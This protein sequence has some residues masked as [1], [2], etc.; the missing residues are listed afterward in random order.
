MRG[1]VSRKELVDL[2]GLSRDFF[3]KNLKG[4]TAIRLSEG[5]TSKI[6]YKSDEV[7]KWF[8]ERGFKE[9]AKKI[10]EGK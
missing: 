4:I 2:T 8:K 9:Y 1:Y 5:K 6:F 3:K 10:E 7:A